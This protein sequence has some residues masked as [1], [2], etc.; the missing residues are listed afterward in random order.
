MTAYLNTANHHCAAKKTFDFRC[1]KTAYLAFL[2]PL[3][4]PFKSQP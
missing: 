1:S 4:K 2:K 3:G